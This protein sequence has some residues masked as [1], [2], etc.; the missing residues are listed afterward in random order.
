MDMGFHFFPTVLLLVDT[1]FFS[2]PWETHALA[3]LMSFSVMAGGYWI[4]VEQCYNYNNFYPYPLM[5]MMTREQRMALFAFATLLCWLS[6][7]IVRGLYRMLNGRIEARSR[8]RAK[9]EI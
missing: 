9:K 1:L 6:F 4:W 2:P 5:G 8:A 7:F 3:A